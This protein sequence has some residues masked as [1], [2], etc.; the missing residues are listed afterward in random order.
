MGTKANASQSLL[1][2]LGPLDRCMVVATF[3]TRLRQGV[4]ACGAIKMAYLVKPVAQTFPHF[5][6]LLA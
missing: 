3:L 2:L 4:R 1:S 5:L 6:L